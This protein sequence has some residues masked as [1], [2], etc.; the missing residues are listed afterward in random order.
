MNNLVSPQQAALESVA[1]AKDAALRIDAVTIV[2]P[3]YNESESID[4]LRDNLNG[5]IDQSHQVAPNLQ[6]Q[7][8]F[9]DDGSSDSTFEDLQ[10]NFGSWPTAQIVRHSTNRG[11]IAAL[12]TG[13][14]VCASDWVAVIDSDCTYDPLLLIQLAQKAE[15][16]QLDV[17]TA[18]PY[19]RLGSVG[20]V[21]AW[22]IAL[23]RVASQLYRW[24]MKNKLTCYTCCVRLY[25]TELVQACSI[26]TAGFVGVTELLWRLDQ[27]GARIGE[28]PATLKPRVTGAS[29]MRTLRTT[30]QHLKFL[31]SILYEKSVGSKPKSTRSNRPNAGSRY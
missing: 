25:R 8:V 29:K 19:H 28:V 16:D 6:W 3:C 24:P 7:F 26:R 12:Q 23:S 2:V 17:V 4:Q 31:A 1:S 15:C 27:V 5:L 22:R 10:R 14:Q 30:I 13:F 21:P 18:S 9:V 11:L 20:N